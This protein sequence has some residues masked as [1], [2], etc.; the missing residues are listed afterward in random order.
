VS[1]EAPPSNTPSIAITTILASCRF[2]R[3]GDVGGVVRG[4]ALNWIHIL[5][6]REGHSGEHR[7]VG[8][9]LGLTPSPPSRARRR[10]FALGFVPAMRQP[11]LS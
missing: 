2:D 1:S 9:L 5:E 4:G 8:C 3:V 11:R 7:G 10:G 6:S